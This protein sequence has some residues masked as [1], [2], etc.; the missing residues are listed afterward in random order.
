[1]GSSGTVI[2]DWNLGWSLVRGGMG[3]FGRGCV[4]TPVARHS[5]DETTINGDGLGRRRYIGVVGKL[6]KGDAGRPVFSRHRG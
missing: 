4:E 6:H 5:I 2:R 3:A 1:M